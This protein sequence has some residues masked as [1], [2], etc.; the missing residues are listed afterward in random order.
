MLTNE[1]WLGYHGLCSQPTNCDCLC[2]V[3]VDELMGEWFNDPEPTDRN[4]NEG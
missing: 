4:L 2:H 1:C 3:T